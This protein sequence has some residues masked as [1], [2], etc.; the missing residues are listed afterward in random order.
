MTQESLELV[1]GT[2]GHVVD[3]LAMIET[4]MRRGAHLR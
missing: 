4:D 2:L 3:R 1:H